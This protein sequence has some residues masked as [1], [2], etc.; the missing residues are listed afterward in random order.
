M[1]RR[2][3]LKGAQLNVTG[4]RIGWTKTRTYWQYRPRF[5]APTARESEP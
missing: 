5:S 2:V 4:G 3:K 1:D